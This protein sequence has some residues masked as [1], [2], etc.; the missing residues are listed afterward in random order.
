MYD[1]LLVGAGLFS[2]TFAYEATKKGKKCLVIEKRNQLG[3]N[4]ATEVLE[5]IHVHKY[6]AHIFH[7]NDR[8]IWDFVNQF[9]EFSSFVNSP[10]ANF[11]GELYNLP[12]NMNTFNKLWGVTTPD[13]AYQ[14]IEEQAKPYCVKP[15]TNLEEQALA[16]V[17]SDIYEKLIKGYTEKQ[18]GRAAKDL[19]SFIIKRLPLRFTFDNNYFSDKYQGIPV[20]GYSSIVE[21]MFAKSDIELSTDFFKNREFHKTRAKQIIFTGMID[22]YYDYQFGALEYRSLRFETEVLEK[23]NYQG[24]AV[25]NFCDFE[26]P[27]TRVIEHKHFLPMENKKTIVTKEYPTEWKKGI[28]PYYPINSEQNSKVYDQYKELSQNESNVIFGGRL[29][30]YSYFDMWQ[31]I[32]IALELA[33]TIS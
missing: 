13:E 1:Y 4:A 21:R 5:G 11:K 33:Q 10:I 30:A 32:K 24:V 18:W 7:T 9:S 8:R 6:G 28:E 25:M 26:T 31:V 16:L 23:T 15:A 22:E 12:F 14:K 2:A 27:F 3:G 19:P 29:G 20:D 17:G